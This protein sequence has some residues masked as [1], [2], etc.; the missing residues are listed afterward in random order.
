MFVVSYPTQNA[1]SFLGQINPVVATGVSLLVGT[2]LLALAFINRDNHRPHMPTFV[3]TKL[4]LPQ[5]EMDRL[6]NLVAT[7]QAEKNENQQLLSELM[8]QKSELQGVVKKK[9]KLV[10]L[11]P[12]FVA[13][14]ASN[15]MGARPW[16][17][18]EANQLDASIETKKQIL[19]HLQ[20]KINQASHQITLT[21]NFV[22]LESRIIDHKTT[23][24]TMQNI[25]NGQE[26]TFGHQ[27][28]ALNWKEKLIY[29][30][31]IALLR[32]GLSCVLSVD[33]EKIR[34]CL[35]TNRNITSYREFNRNG[36]QNTESMMREG[37]QM[38]HEIIKTEQG[39]SHDRH[40]TMYLLN[41]REQA[42]Q[43]KK[44]IDFVRMSV[45][46]FNY[47]VDNEDDENAVLQQV[48]RAIDQNIQNSRLN[49]VIQ[50]SK[51][52]ER[53]LNDDRLYSNDIVLSI[54]PLDDNAFDDWDNVIS[55]LNSLN[56]RI[57]NVENALLNHLVNAF[58]R[59]RSNIL[60][61]DATLLV[62]HDIFRNV[63]F[64]YIRNLA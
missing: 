51:E 25:L 55:T 7:I 33:K 8:T 60:Q 15:L 49:N 16:L 14:P 48:C 45:N 46:N 30:T 57:S 40:T 24:E 19:A 54:N 3:P 5:T 18:E 52:L 59:E 22:N 64:N 27:W 6:N 10:N 63:T 38:M 21:K 50:L 12:N 2:A 23:T 47:Q 31:P 56:N 58:A 42:A 9:D 39:Q 1:T 53:V 4:D 36:N 13:R 35:H 34:N 11:L 43:L 41:T 32:G 61:L 29:R 28:K 37:V 26:Q 62:N 17:V 20:N 44:Q